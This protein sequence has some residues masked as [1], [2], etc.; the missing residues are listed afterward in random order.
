M[1]KRSVPVDPGE[2]ADQVVKHATKKEEDRGEECWRE[3]GPPVLS[4]GSAMLNV[5]IAD[6]VDVAYPFGII[7]NIV[8]DSHS[9]KTLLALSTLAEACYNS[10][11]CEHRLIHDDAEF[12]NRF[13]IETMFG[14]K[15][16]ERLERPDAFGDRPRYS[17]TIQDFELRIHRLL[18]QGCPFIYVMDSL[19][20]LS[21]DEEMD[22][23][24]ANLTKREKGSKETGSYG[25]G[26]ARHMS[27]ILR[28]I[29]RRL[30]ATKSIL[31][32][33][34]QTRDNLD[35]FSFQT[36]T[37][38]GGRALKF[39][40]A[41]EM[42]LAS[43]KKIEARDRVI[44]VNCLVGVTKTRMTG[45]ARSVRFPVYYSYGIDDIGACVEFLVKEKIWSKSGSGTISGDLGGRKISG[46]S[47]KVIAAIEDADGIPAL[48]ELVQKAWDEVEE[49]IRLKRKPKY[50]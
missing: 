22:K 45:K 30:E 1:I 15:L 25:D 14:R 50:E 47:A 7:V 3:V 20:A 34:S 28:M 35:A 12:G 36:K 43:G 33:I 9:G 18:D 38:S 6:R 2:L 26:K 49:S 39:Y 41:V 42:W 8:G 48:R 17:E 11:F 16:A 24:S 46:Q 5:A 31:I 10:L 23:T 19:D 37:R 27:Q 32:I 13:K 44:G 40:S 21:S 4:S 29:V